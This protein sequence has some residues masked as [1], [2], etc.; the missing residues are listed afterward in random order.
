MAL[1]SRMRAVT[2]SILPAAGMANQ[3]RSGT[4]SAAAPTASA[5][6]GGTEIAVT[7]GGLADAMLSLAELLHAV[8]RRWRH[9]LAHLPSVAV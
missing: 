5:T 8:P 7:S 2:A 3:E 4:G 9:H 1:P 6:P